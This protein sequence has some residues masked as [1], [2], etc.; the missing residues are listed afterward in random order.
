MIA[1]HAGRIGKTRESFRILVESILVKQLLGRTRRRRKVIHRE[2]G[3]KDEMLRK[4]AQDF[5]QWLILV[6]AALNYRIR[7]REP[8]LD[9]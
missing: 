2:T 1:E 9:V 6:L 4:L 7:L 8:E 3:R 5:A